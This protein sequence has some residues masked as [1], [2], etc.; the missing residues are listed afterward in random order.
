[1]DTANAIR[2]R[3]SVTAGANRITVARDFSPHLGARYPSDGPFGGAEFRDSLL[4]PRLER[5]IKEGQ[6]LVVDF[7]EVAGIPSSFAEETFGGLFR[8]RPEWSLS[9]VKS[10]LRLQAPNSPRLWSKLR[11]AETYMES[12]NARKRLD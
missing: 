2:E 12:A 11:L 4:I 7:D 3:S 6:L 8:A 9:L 1:M 5:A 10:H